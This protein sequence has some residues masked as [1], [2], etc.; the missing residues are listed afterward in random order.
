MQGCLAPSLPLPP[1]LFLSIPPFQETEHQL[2]MTPAISKQKSHEKWALLNC[3][4][5]M[6][7]TKEN[8]FEYEIS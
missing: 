1:F 5:K 2:R 4:T 7:L 8:I 6:A 3:V